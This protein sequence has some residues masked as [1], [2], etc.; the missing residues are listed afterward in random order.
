[1]AQD[2]PKLSDLERKRA[3]EIAVA[4]RR[5]RS[6]AKSELIAGRISI[7]DL[8]NDPRPAI[9]KMRVFD[10]LLAVPGVG[11]RRAYLLMEKFGISKGR[12]IGGLG[13]K[14]ISAL[15]SELIL[16][17]KE[18]KQGSLIVM[19]GPGG[20]GKS[21]ITNALRNHPSIWVSVSA[22]TRE[23]RESESDGIDYFFLTDE[24]FDQMIKAGEFLEWAEFAG[25]RYGTPKA[26]VEEARRLGKHVLLEIEIAGARQV[27]IVEP[28]ALLVFISPPSWEEL[29]ARLTNRGTDSPERRAARLALAEEEMAAADS[30]DHI[31]INHSVEGVAEQLLSLAST[32]G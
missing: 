1:M 10:L 9:Q 5:D 27:R 32:R 2:P 31:L 3:S 20:V 6:V 23:P 30:F 28:N 8:I 7:F 11:D 26:P 15:R 25:N 21:T 4:S 19:S 17:K 14:Q 18:P 12:R 13:P 16:N 22:T 29:V 24:K